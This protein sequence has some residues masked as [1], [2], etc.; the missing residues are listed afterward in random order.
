VFVQRQRRSSAAGTLLVFLLALLVMCLG[1]IGGVLFYR[2]Y[3]RE[4][5]HRQ[6]RGMCGFPYDAKD[7][8]NEVWSYNKQL[9]EDENA[10]NL[11]Q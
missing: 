6:W 8:G 5:Y 3:M 1:M 10:S 7:T 2:T 9:Q 11:L 4:N